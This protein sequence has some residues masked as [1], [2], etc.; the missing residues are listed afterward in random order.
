M[1]WLPAVIVLLSVAAP[2]A[3][4]SAAPDCGPVQSGIVACLG[5]KLCVC[6]TG[7]SAAVQR[8]WDCGVLRPW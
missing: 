6:R 3:A 7:D 5:G 4:A 8:G 1:R 2:A